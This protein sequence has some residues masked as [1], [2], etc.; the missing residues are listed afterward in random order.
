MRPTAR[1]FRLWCAG[2]LSAALV[3]LPSCGAAPRGKILVFAAASLTDVLQAQAET[4]GKERSVRVD[5]N[6]GASNSLAQQ[7]ARGAPADVFISAGVQPVEELEHLGLAAPGSA[8]E[9][10]TNDL[11]LVAPSGAGLVRSLDDLRN[12][13]VRLAIAD[14]DLAPAGLYARQALASLGL[15]PAVQP[16]LVLGREVRA[17]LAYVESGSA[18]AA[19]VYHTDV[20]TGRGMQ[21]VAT[22]PADSHSQIVYSAVVLKASANGA[23]AAAFLD[24]LQG[25]SARE[26][27]RTYGFTPAAR[28]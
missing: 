24:F 9:L 27:F 12:P 10:L 17:T 28:K 20:Q 23:S 13:N 21:V 14:P 26:V 7:I 15:W 4:F 16:R 19:V 6:F 5:I 8:R 25:P 18:D 3:L 22:F 11:V 1:A 2:V